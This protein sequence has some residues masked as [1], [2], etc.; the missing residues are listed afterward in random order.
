[1]RRGTIFI[2]L[3]FVVAVAVVAAS[4]FFRAQPPLE[5]RVA[6]SP[7]VEGWVT[8]AVNALNATNPLVNSTRR[9]HY[10]VETIDDVQVWLDESRQWTP[11]SHPQA[12]IPAT[13]FSVQF[14]SENRL[15][16]VVVQPS[17]ARTMLIWGGFSSFVNEMTDDDAAQFDWM[18]VAEAAP[19][20]PL[21]FNNP[22]RTVSG[23]SVLLSGA[24]A[25]HDTAALTGV[26]VNAPDFR[27]WIEPVIG[28]V[29]NFTT[30]G[31]SAAE[32]LA[33]RGSSNGQI[34]FLPEAEWLQNLRGFLAQ[35]G[36]PIVL[37]YPQYTVVFEF[38]LARWNDSTNAANADE[39]AAVEA[40]G[41]WLTNTAQQ[42]HA[43]NFGLRPVQGDPVAGLF[44]E[45]ETYG[46]LISP[47]VQAVQPP[48]RNDL[49]QLVGWVGTIVR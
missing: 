23:L 13:A 37:S 32:T 31:A 42:T 7:L 16:F 27:D 36:D 9:A 4:Q 20:A 28:A 43:E 25:F 22:A 1:M 6:V 8:E 38:P 48:S 24:A 33:A 39:A 29:P 18:A 40:L 11:E 17:V 5:I 44:A 46:A 15:P 49:R 19:N 10:S 3:F 2:I 21:A 26:E 35:E 12:W 45:G 47:A 30:L 41:N 34:G 14:A